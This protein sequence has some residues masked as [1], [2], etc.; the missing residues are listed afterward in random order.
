MKHYRHLFFDLDHTLWD[1]RTNSRETLREL[2]AAHG[3]LARGIP[4][5]EA[6]IGV[7]EE[8]NHRLWAEHGAGRMPKEVM[9]VL[10]FRSALQHFGVVDGRLPGK[11][12]EE[13]LAQ[14]PLKPALMPGAMELLDAVAGSHRLHI[15]TNGFEDVQHV[16]LVHSGIAPRFDVVLTSE[17]AGAAKPSAAIFAEALKRSGAKAAESLMI[18]DN[19]DTD[20]LG[21][22]SAGWDQAHY[23]AETDPD[24]MATH[25]AVHHDE[26]RRLLA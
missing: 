25:R 15:I 13:Y 11:L 3:L 8:I 23:H 6:F 18:G 1:F 10:R 14:C 12:S 4:D 17:R 9:R 21:A 20:M 2:V 19:A 5:A 22:R 7:Y 24:P 26:L 16:K